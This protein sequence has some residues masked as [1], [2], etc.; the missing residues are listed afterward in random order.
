MEYTHACIKC[1]TE[2]SDNDFDAYY[3]A[4]C[5][6]EHKAKAEEI[7]NKINA[8]PRKQVKSDFQRYEELV[9]LRGSKFININEM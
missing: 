2:Y 4:K 3:C 7:Q 6:K 9:K 8:R 5:L 1:S